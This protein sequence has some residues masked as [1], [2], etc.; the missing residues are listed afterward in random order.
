MGIFLLFISDPNR[1]P[2]S[3]N[4][5][6]FSY[7]S[8]GSVSVSVCT[9]RAAAGWMTRQ[10]RCLGPRSGPP[11]VREG[12][13]GGRRRPDFFLISLS[14]M[15]S[16]AFY[17]KFCRYKSHGFFN[18]GTIQISWLANNKFAHIFIVPVIKWKFSRPQAIKN[19]R[20]MLQFHRVFQ[21]VAFIFSHIKFTI[22]F[23][24]G[25]RITMNHISYDCPPRSTK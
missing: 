7:R 25:R 22:I 21:S 1:S 17:L 15:H 3:V 2:N 16:I 4:R 24:N 13:L 10:G 14:K 9:G 11:K 8:E 19:Y 23:V 6:R 20:Q 5:Y 12:P 18:M